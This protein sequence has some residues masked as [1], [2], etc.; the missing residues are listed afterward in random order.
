[1]EAIHERL[2]AELDRL[3]LSLAAAARAM[4][5]PDAQGLRDACTGRKRVTAEMLARAVPLGVDA[6]YVLTGQRL[7]PVEST[8]TPEERALLDNY[9]HSDEEARR[10]ARLVLNAL[11]Q[12]K[13]A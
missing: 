8:L 4:G 7:Q 12:R 5:E 1:M 2:R 9:Q 10:S 6:M 13:A 11:A 3:D